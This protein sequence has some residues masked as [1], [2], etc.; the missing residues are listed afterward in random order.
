MT[1]PVILLRAKHGSAT[2]AA[3]RDAGGGL[4][5]RGCGISG[6]WGLHGRRKQVTCRAGAGGNGWRGGSRRRIIPPWNPSRVEQRIGRIDRIGQRHAVLPIRNVFLSGS[7]D[8]RVY[9]VLGAR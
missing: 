3:G 4:A 8:Q 5:S 9:Q 2:S 6:A 1:R 7:I